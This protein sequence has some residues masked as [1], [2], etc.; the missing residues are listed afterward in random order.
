[1][2]FER[3]TLSSPTVNLPSHVRSCLAAYFHKESYSA[4]QESFSGSLRREMAAILRA[5]AIVG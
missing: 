2:P 4:Q 1:M 5:S 3:I